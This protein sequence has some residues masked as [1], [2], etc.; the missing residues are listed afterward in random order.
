MRKKKETYLG[1][2]GYPLKK[3]YLTFLF[4]VWKIGDLAP[5]REMEEW[6]NGRN[7][8]RWEKGEGKR[9]KRKREK[10]EKKIKIKI[11]KRKKKENKKE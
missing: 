5:L 1:R 11:K 9:K 6:R 7:E 4:R 10:K 3:G 2:L 8:K